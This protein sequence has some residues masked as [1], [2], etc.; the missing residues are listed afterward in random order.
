VVAN[1]WEL[2]VTARR[3][4]QERMQFA[5]QIDLNKHGTPGGVK[6]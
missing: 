1:R 2:I 5:R 3:A 4:R 6:S